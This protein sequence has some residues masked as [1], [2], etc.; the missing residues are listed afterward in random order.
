MQLFCILKVYN[1]NILLLLILLFQINTFFN[2]KIHIVTMERKIAF[3]FQ[4]KK[5]FRKCKLLQKINLQMV[6]LTLQKKQDEFLKHKFPHTMQI[7]NVAIV[8]KPQGQG[9]EVR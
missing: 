1:L 5:L 8:F 2:M 7:P 6:K 3:S 4:T 9:H